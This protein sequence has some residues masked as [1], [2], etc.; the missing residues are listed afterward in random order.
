MV[1]LLE[2]TK[3]RL[4]QKL[5]TYFFTN[6]E[7]N[8]Y[9]REISSLLQEDAGNLSKELARLE[10]KGIFVS[11][12]R[13]NQKYFSL[14]KKYPLYREFRAVIFKTIGIEGS[15][16]EIIRQIEGMDAAFIYGSF[17]Q[18]KENATSD[19]D[20]FIIG[21]PDEDR[22]MEEIERIEKKLQRE[23]NYNIYSKK[24]FIE[25][26]KKKDSFILNILKGPKVML[27]GRLD[28]I[29]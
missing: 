27:K 16:K 17:A 3:S 6:P 8:L 15:L 24:E 21:E 11:H 18:D 7:A 29:R 14:N 19:I 5:L 1:N 20:L 9:L 2:L 22:L 25:R 13:G 23:I 28:G 26:R 10:K 12:A 4:R